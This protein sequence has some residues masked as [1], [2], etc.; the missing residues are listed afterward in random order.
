MEGSA[1]PR[2]PPR[3]Q[4]TCILKTRNISIDRF[5]LTKSVFYFVEELKSLTQK[6]NIKQ[7]HRKLDTYTTKFLRA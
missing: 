2:A 3:L 7:N 4:Y 1:P 6:P 5:E